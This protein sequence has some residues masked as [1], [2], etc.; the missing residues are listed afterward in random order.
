MPLISPEALNTSPKQDLINDHALSFVLR[1]MPLAVWIVGQSLEV[2]E[3]GGALAPA[4]GLAG[5]PLFEV[6][7]S[8]D[9]TVS[10]VSETLAALA[11]EPSQFEFV[12]KEK[13]LACV[14]EPLAREGDEITHAIAFAFDISVQRML[15]E[16]LLAAEQRYRDLFERSQ[17]GVLTTDLEGRV[18]T[19]NSSAASLTGYEREGLLSKNICELVAGDDREDLRADM[20]A[21][22]GGAIQVERRTALVRKHGTPLPVQLHVRLLF[23]DGIPSGIQ[24]TLRPIS[25]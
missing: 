19:V 24:A 16:R 2:E 12:W 20:R 15:G 11:G 23:E 4:L 8:D 5:L 7:G 9:P 14:I 25:V 17:D 1:C 10:P 13:N 22:V 6:F 3:F 18:L 21:I